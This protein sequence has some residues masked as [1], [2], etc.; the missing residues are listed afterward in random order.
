MPAVP[1]PNKPETGKAELRARIYP[2]IGAIYRKLSYIKLNSIFMELMLKTKLVTKSA[3]AKIDFEHRTIS[4]FQAKL[5]LKQL[6][7]RNLLE[8]KPLREFYLVN[9]R[10]EVLRQLKKAGYFFDGFWYERPVSPERYYK[11]VNF[12]EKKCPV[13]V[14]VSKRIINFPTYYQP[15]EMERAKRIVWEYMEE[16]K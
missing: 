16:T 11:K 8:K 15:K 9:N 6:K 1:I 2:T 10:E 5:A 4:Y 7:K 13:A 3:D 14:E 12:P